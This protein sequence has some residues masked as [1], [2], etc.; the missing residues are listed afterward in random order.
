MINFNKQSRSIR[1]LRLFIDNSLGIDVNVAHFSGFHLN[2]PLLE[3]SAYNT[4]IETISDKSDTIYS[5]IKNSR[6]DMILFSY[7]DLIKAISPRCGFKE[8]KL[9]LAFDYTDEDFY[10]EVQGLEIHGTKKSDG[11]TGAFR[12][13]TCSI[14][15]DDVSEKI[16]LI[17]IPISLGHS[18]AK[19]I[20]YCLSLLRDLIGQISLIIFDRGFYSKDLMYTLNLVNYPYLIFIPKNDQ[21]KDEL[22][23][24]K[25]K[26]QKMQTYEFEVNKDKTKYVGETLQ[27]F[28]KSVYSKRLDK[29]FDWAFATNVANIELEN[30]IRTY[31]KRW[32][33]ET[34]FR[35]QDEAQ[36]KCKSKDMQIRYFLFM[37]EQMLQTLWVCFYKEEV[38]FKEF[39]IEMSKTCKLLV[40]ND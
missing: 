22:D 27:I 29:E 25:A 23:K 7:L 3:A 30:L 20:G 35:V 6:E 18:M 33:I 11:K 17:S 37:Y 24:M 14:I 19:E 31:K 15:S 4:Y 21:I 10:G 32:R 2:L 9:I 16:P 40:K 1:T 26:E 39:I 28:L 5:R 12:F 13:L 34:G 38:S 36:I 8:K